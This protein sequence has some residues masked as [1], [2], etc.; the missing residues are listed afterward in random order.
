MHRI[1]NFVFTLPFGVRGTTFFIRASVYM[2]DIRLELYARTRRRT[3][4]VLSCGNLD[5]ALD[6]FNF[7]W[8]DKD[9]IRSILEK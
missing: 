1:L 9:R 8:L 3:D 4:C 2:L 5:K 7:F 6:V